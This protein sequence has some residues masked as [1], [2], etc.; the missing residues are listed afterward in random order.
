MSACV[1]CGARAD[2]KEHVFAKRLLFKQK[3]I[4]GLNL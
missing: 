1:V 2:S 3:Q 4:D